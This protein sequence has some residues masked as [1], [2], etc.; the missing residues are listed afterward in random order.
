MRVVSCLPGDD[1]TLELEM[2]RRGEAHACRL[3][4]HLGEHTQLTRLYGELAKTV[5][6]PA[7]VKSGNSERVVDSWVDL[8]TNIMEQSQR[9]Y[10]VQRYKGLGEMNPE[11]LW[12]TTMDPEVRTLMRVEADD[13]LAADTMF[14]IL[15]GD[16]VEPRRD[17]IQKNALSVRNLDV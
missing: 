9:G 6:L 16:A 12:E 10:D 5:V 17:F 11:Q 4:S 2:E 15:M 8:L 13:L 7:T 14:T 3:A 1:D